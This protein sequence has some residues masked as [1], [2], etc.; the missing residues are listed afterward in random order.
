M[1]KSIGTPSLIFPNPVLIVGTYDAQGRANAVN[2]AWGGIA[3][4]GPDAVSIAVRP[5]RYSYENLMNRKAFTINLPTVEQVASA[6][7]FGIVSGRDVDKFAATG[8]TPVR[9]TYV[10]APWIEEYPYHLECEVSHTL[11]LGAHTLFIG[12]IR[13][14][15]IDEALMGADGKPT[16]GENLLTYDSLARVYRRPGTIVAPAFSVGRDIASGA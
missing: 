16:F 2:L 4:S 10:D 8:L 7:Y 11:D 9:G 5:S 13:D 3:S 12:R 6:D 14:V 15:S 1:K